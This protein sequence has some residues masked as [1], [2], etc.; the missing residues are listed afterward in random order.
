MNDI[1]VWPNGK[2]VAVSTTVMFETYSDGV[3]PSYSVQTSSLKH[4]TPDHA[5]MAWVT[6]G[7][8]VGVWRIVRLLDELKIKGTFFINAR[9]AEQY[10]EAVK[11]IARSGHDIGAHGYT[12]DRLLAYQS[13]GEQEATIRDCVGALEACSGA[14]I[15]GWVS[16]VLAFT[17]ETV[18]CIAK[19]GLRWTSDVTYL[20]LPHRIHTRSGT[21]AAIPTSDFSDNRVMKASPRGLLEAHLGTLQYLRECEGMSLMTL[22]FHCQFGGRPMM[23][24]VIR[25][26]LQTIARYD[27][28]WF[29]THHE[30]AEWAFA[31]KSDECSYRE[32][33]FG[34]R[35][36]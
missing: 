36:G 22:V 6:Y 20:D 14:K 23:S 30:L 15:T 18:D 7:G 25:E 1:R 11:Q 34:G 2:K 31:A 3:A 4:G 5:A 13:P 21:I 12:Q 24:A 27:D 19:C 32:R 35:P 29:A 17:P 28:V 33:F 16:P 9:C 8:R 26:L 10:P